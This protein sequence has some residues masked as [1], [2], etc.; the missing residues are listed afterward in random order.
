M[1]LGHRLIVVTSLVAMTWT[2]S[3]HA[4]DK[5]IAPQKRDDSLAKALTLLEPKDLAVPAG[6][7]DVFYP[8]QFDEAIRAASNAAASRN[9]DVSPGQG[10]LVE[11]VAV[12]LTPT[13]ILEVKGELVLLFGEKRVRAGETI[14]AILPDG[15][16]HVAA[17]VS[18][19]PPYFTFRVG[20][21]VHSRLLK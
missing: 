17:V 8:A 16:R 19:T 3:L 5:V 4:N 18:V 7:S 10:S 9:A 2:A 6:F 1:A 13:G 11:R 12:A 21:E 20:N 15:S 14:V